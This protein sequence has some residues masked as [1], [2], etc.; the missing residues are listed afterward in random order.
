M[1]VVPHKVS[2]NATTDSVQLREVI[3]VPDPYA[4]R[5]AGANKYNF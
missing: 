5:V 4:V 3:T 1:Y 2:L